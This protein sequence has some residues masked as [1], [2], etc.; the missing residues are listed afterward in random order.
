ML[1]L[2][3]DKMKIKFSSFLKSIKTKTN[4]ELLQG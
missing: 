2:K 4:V 3:I 1:Y